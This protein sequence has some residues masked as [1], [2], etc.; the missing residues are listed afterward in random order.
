MDLCR[1]GIHSCE[2]DWLGHV[3]HSRHHEGSSTRMHSLSAWMLLQCN[4]V[5][6]AYGVC[7]ASRQFYGKEFKGIFSSLDQAIVDPT[8][9]K[10]RE[11]ISHMRVGYFHYNF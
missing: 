10:K 9:A 11:H 8:F 5:G 4:H 1:V 7:S 6:K 2:S 3:L